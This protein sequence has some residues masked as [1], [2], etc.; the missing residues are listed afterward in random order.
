MQLTSELEARTIHL[1]NQ[2]TSRIIMA[3]A[4]TDAGGFVKFVVDSFVSTTEFTEVEAAATLSLPTA[5]SDDETAE[6][7]E[8]TLQSPGS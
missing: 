3:F 5:P 6:E 2:A 1:H 4:G 7:E 8:E